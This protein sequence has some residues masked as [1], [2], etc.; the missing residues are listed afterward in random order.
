MLVDKMVE[1]AMVDA[2]SYET[3]RWT[4]KTMPVNRGKRKNGA[5]PQSKTPAL[6]ARWKRS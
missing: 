2:V 5:V 1:L 6:S 3:I 4:L